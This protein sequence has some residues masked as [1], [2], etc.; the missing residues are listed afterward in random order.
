MGSEVH[1]DMFDDRLVIYSPGGMADGAIY[2]IEKLII[3]YQYEEI[4]YW[5]MFLIDWG[6]GASGKWLGEDTSILCL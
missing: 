3:Y 5:Q 1:I 2:R 4:K 6:Y